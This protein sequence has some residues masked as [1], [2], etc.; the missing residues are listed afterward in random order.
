MRPSLQALV[1]VLFEIARVHTTF[2]VQLAKLTHVLRSSK[3]R[4]SDVVA[5][6]V[7]A[8]LAD[9]GPLL[10][11]AHEQDSILSPLREHS[12]FARA[13]DRLPHNCRLELFARA[14]GHCVL[15]PVGPM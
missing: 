13:V 3:F 11:Q 12:M 4:N 9:L 14:D 6:R 1:P 7:D 5:K 8:N 15:E 2:A 10:K